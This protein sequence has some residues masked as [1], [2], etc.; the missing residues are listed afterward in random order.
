MGETSQA[1]RRMSKDTKVRIRLTCCRGYK[2]SGCCWNKTGEAR[3]L[4]REEGQIRE[5][6]MCLAEEV[7]ALILIKGHRDL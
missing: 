1:K 6:L 5:G 3:V 4:R 7:R 2:E